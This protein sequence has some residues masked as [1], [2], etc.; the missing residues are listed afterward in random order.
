MAIC[1][2]TK[3]TMN[4]SP[5]EQPMNYHIDFYKNP[6]QY[7]CHQHMFRNMHTSPV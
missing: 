5:E 3:Y 6:E 4:Y 2:V 7:P 1:M